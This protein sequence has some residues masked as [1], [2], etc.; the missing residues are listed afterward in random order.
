MPWNT[1]HKQQSRDQILTAAAALFSHKGFDAVSIDDVMQRA[2]L[3]RGAFYAHFKSKSDLYNEA[4]MHGGLY[5]RARLHGKD[6]LTLEQLAERY[7]YRNL[8]NDLDQYCPLAFLVTDIAHRDETV[9]KTYRRMVKGYQQ[10][11]TSL[12]LNEANAVAASVLLIG[13]L[14]MTRAVSD[15]E[16]MVEQLRENCFRVV[17]LLSSQQST[18]TNTSEINEVT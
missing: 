14:A 3:T 16:H 10:H 17:A 18:S 4:I 5:A 13:G 11:L 8:D 15:D 9:R 12:G 6:T 1:E 2:G 7:L